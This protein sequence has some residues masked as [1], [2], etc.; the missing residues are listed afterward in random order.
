MYS[1][2]RADVHVAGSYGTVYSVTPPLAEY[3]HT[4]DKPTHSH[5][6]HRNPCSSTRIALASVI[7]TLGLSAVAY[8]SVSDYSFNGVA[9]EVGSTHYFQEIALQHAV[10]TLTEQMQAEDVCGNGPEAG[11]ALQC[12]MWNN[13]TLWVNPRIL[14]SSTDMSSGFETSVLD[15]T[16]TPR[17]VSRPTAVLVA[18]NGTQ[19][20]WVYGKEAHCIGH[21]IAVFNGLYQ[22]YPFR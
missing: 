8:V 14:E 18:F 6:P 11:V 12:I 4:P 22:P 16:D 2:R 9:F 19:Q 13:G 7:C 15:R 10:R 17:L 3:A 20:Q 1:R 21:A 5:R